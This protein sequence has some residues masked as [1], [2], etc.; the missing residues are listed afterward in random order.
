MTIDYGTI[1]LATF[2]KDSAGLLPKHYE[3]SAKH[4]DVMVLDPDIA[5]YEGLEQQGNLS[6]IAAYKEGKMIGYSI[7]FITNNMHYKNLMMGH[8]DILFV[9]TEHR[10][11]KVGLKLISLSEKICKEEGCEVYLLHAKEDS[12]LHRLCPRLGYGVQD[13]IFSKRL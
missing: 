13:I 3:E 5:K 9:D 4:K 1:D 7:N 8:N 6:I 10:N 12:P 2:V 11:S